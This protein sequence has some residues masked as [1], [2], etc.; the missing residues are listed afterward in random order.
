MAIKRS[1]QYVEVIEI[2]DGDPREMA[3]FVRDTL[4]NAYAEE[5]TTISKE[6]GEL[7]PVCVLTDWK[8]E[9]KGAHF[10][11]IHWSTYKKTSKEDFFE[12]SDAFGNKEG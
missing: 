4:N 3:F 8:V 11:I 5:R 10:L 9:F 2:P 7:M 6:Y 1:D 12:G